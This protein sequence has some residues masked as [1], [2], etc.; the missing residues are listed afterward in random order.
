MYE[1]AGFGELRSNLQVNQGISISLV[2][3]W[4]SAPCITP[5]LR[6]LPLTR[7]QSISIP[8]LRGSS[9]LRYGN[10]GIAKMLL[11]ALVEHAKARGLMSGTSMA[12]PAAVTFYEKHGW[13]RIPTPGAPRYHGVGLVK[14]DLL[15]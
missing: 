11:Q 8:S 15:L 10:L 2:L 7:V 13:K 4:V 5:S 12:Q 14:V 9:S 6:I 1:R 3:N